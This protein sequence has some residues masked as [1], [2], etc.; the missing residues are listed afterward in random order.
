MHTL[1]GVQHFGHDSWKTSTQDTGRRISIR[2]AS[3]FPEATLDIL[4]CGQSLTVCLV[5]QD[6]HGYERA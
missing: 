4:S 1:R 2:I 3:V 6:R 5:A